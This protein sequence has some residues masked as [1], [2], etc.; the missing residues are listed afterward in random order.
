AS[1]AAEA[2]AAIAARL[3]RART[4][5]VRGLGSPDPGAVSFALI[6]AALT[7]DSP[8]VPNVPEPEPEESH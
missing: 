3:G 8:D 5:G 6:V 2:T 7:P 4:H 1:E